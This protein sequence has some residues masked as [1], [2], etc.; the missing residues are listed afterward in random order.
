MGV[1]KL[2]LEKSD[3]SV[4]KKSPLVRTDKGAWGQMIYA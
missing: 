1:K 2:A 4:N 3:G